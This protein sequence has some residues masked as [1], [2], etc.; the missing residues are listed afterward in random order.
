MT[1]KAHIAF[2]NVEELRQLIKLPFSQPSAY[3]CNSAIS[4]AC[5]EGARTVSG[6][7][8]HGSKFQDCEF[9]AVLS[10]PILAEQ[11]RS[12]G[13]RLY[14]YRKDDHERRCRRDKQDRTGNIKGSFAAGKSPW[15]HVGKAG[16]ESGWACIS[17]DTGLVMHFLKAARK[18]RQEQME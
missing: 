18:K 11:K 13:S 6:G 16:S 15:G 1:H 10:D 12:W 8:V 5:D 14:D 17:H 7:G 4:R 9:F 2:E 3:R